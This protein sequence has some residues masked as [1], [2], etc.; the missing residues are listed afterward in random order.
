L[1]EDQPLPQ[2]IIIDGGQ[3]SAA[4]KVLMIRIERKNSDIGIRGWK[5]YFILRIQS[6]IFR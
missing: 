6:F 1:D 3:L 5:S 2:L 4:L